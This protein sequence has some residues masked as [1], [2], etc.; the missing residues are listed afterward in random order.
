MTA[1]PTTIHEA[2]A[3]K[4]GY[5]LSLT[6]CGTTSPLDI[7]SHEVEGGRAPAASASSLA[8]AQR[9]EGDSSRDHYHLVNGTE[10]K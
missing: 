3:F 1:L 6:F 4:V 9:I 5:K 10:G 2:C 8:V 7:R